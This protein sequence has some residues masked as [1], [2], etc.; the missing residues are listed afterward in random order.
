MS[1]RGFFEIFDRIRDKISETLV[2]VISKSGGTKETRNGM[3]EA[4]EKFK[5][6]NIDF[7]KQAVAVTGRD[8]EKWLK[9]LNNLS[10]MLQ[11]GAIRFS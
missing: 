6:Q 4:E 3:L 9:R 1:P 8:W 7:S 5:Q 10:V 2:I 11:H